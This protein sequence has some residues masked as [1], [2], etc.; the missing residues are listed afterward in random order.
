MWLGC[1]TTVL[2]LLPVVH[3]AARRGTLSSIASS[4]SVLLINQQ[5]ETAQVREF[6]AGTVVYIVR[7]DPDKLTPNEDAIALLPVGDTAGVLVIADGCGGQANGQLAS[8][9]AIEAMADSVRQWEQPNNLRAPILDGFEAAIQRVRQ[10][11]TGAATTLIAVEINARVI[12]TFHV[13]DSQALLVGSRGKI[14]LMT[15]S[16]SP[17]GYAME[18]G[19]LTEKAA[20]QHEDRHLVSN[21]IGADDSH[22]DMGLPRT[23]DAQDTLLIGSDGLYDNLRLDEIVQLIRKGPLPKVAATLANLV[24]HRMVSPSTAHPSKPDDLAIVLFRPCIATRRGKYPLPTHDESQGATRL[25]DPADD[26][27]QAARLS[28]V[29]KE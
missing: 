9:L 17:V 2:E 27:G 7:R 16:H 13:G 19:M 26:L 22:I 14:K 21:V 4:E 8:Q 25:G 23:L 24:H 11:G 28:A 1:A 10:L 12:R 29:V 18:A 15:Q 20:L 6:A 5:L 3:D